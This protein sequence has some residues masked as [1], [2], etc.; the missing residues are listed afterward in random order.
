MASNFTANSECIPR[1]H[2]AF[3]FAIIDLTLAFVLICFYDKWKMTKILAVLGLGS[4]FI[5]GSLQEKGVSNRHHGRYLM[6]HAALCLG[7]LRVLSGC[8]L[9][10]IST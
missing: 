4:V 9:Q 1:V 2:F 3:A 7:N 10:N 8:K 6:N 5:S